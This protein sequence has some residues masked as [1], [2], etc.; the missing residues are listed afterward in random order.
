M[1]KTLNQILRPLVPN[2]RLRISHTEPGV[3]LQVRLRQHLGL[4]AR[5]AKSYESRYVDVLRAAINPGET[6]FDVGAN[7]G[8]YSVLFSRWVG[9]GGRVFAFEPDPDNVALL[10]RNLEMNGC[11]NSVVR[12]VALGRTREAGVF[13]RD[14]ATGATGHLGRG[15]TYGETLFGAGRE[16]LIP[17]KTETLDAESEALGPPAVV[18]LDIEGGEY[19]VLCGGSRVLRQERPLVISELSAWADDGAYGKT[20]AALAVELFQDQDYQVWNLDTGAPV[21]NG[22]KVWMVLAVP[23]ERGGEE[24]ALRAVEK[25]KESLPA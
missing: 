24:R 9:T 20:R 13:S 6:I 2:I 19:E 18:K 17:V 22:E 5:G 3:A 4:I 11:A 10:R 12:E 14:P 1:S 7:I 15:P 8:F 23:R 16:F 21:S 25:L